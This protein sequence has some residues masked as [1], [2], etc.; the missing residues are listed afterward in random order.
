MNRIAILT[1]EMYQ[2]HI[3]RRYQEKSIL[4]DLFVVNKF[5]GWTGLTIIVICLGVFFWSFY[6]NDEGH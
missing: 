2:T 3:E 4:T 5:W 1:M 6:P